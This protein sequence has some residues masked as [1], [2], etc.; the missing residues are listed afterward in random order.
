MRVIVDLQ[1]GVDMSGK[2]VTFLATLVVVTACSGASTSTIVEAASAT[3]LAS[4]TTT[5]ATTT[6]LAPTTTTSV[7]LTTT[8]LESASEPL[9]DF[10]IESDDPLEALDELIEIYNWLWR[11]P[12][13]A[14]LS[15]A[16]TTETNTYQRLTRRL[17]ELK[18]AGQS[19]DDPGLVVHSA[20]IDEWP[21]E[22]A[23]VILR[24]TIS[25]EPQVIVN[26]D[27]VVEEFEGYEPW[28]TRL[29]MSNHPGSW[30]LITIDSFPEIL[31]PR[32]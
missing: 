13:P 31:E 21:L 11:N 28:E 23:V 24:V 16:F 14:L 15:A 8:T 12:E 18:E 32:S 9:P 26:A 1:G 22:D 30:R 20:E 7:P 27:G 2:Y 3:T 29:S 5:E 6:T 25:W 10:L 4:T 17:S 19:H